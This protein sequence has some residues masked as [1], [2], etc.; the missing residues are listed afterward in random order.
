MNGKKTWGNVILYTDLLQGIE[1][2][3]GVEKQIYLDL[4]EIVD[5]VFEVKR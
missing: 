4:K 3:C 2:Y 5:K 1:K